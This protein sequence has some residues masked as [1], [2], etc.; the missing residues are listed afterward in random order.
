MKREILSSEFGFCSGGLTTYEFASMNV[1]FAIICDEKHQLK[2]ARE[3]ERRKI[4]LNLGMIKKITKK[5]IKKIILK[6]MD[7]QIK[8][9]SGR[10]VVDG[11]GSIR[12]ANEIVKIIEKNY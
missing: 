12:A 6:L 9:K 5:D 8:L 4:A 3:W 11:K 10:K 2:T 7:N 1:P